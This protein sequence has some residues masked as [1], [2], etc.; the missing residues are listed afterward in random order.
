[1]IHPKEQF[2]VVDSEGKRTA[3]VLP[4][5]QYKRI[6]DTVYY[7]QLNGDIRDAKSGRALAARLARES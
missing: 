4:L 7:Q 1:M 6:L 5:Q 3:V 2:I